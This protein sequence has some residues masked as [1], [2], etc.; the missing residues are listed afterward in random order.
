MF[1]QR[2]AFIVLSI[3]LLAIA[4]IVIAVTAQASQRPTISGSTVVPTSLPLTS[5]LAPEEQATNEAML[6]HARDLM[7]RCLDPSPTPSG[8][9]EKVREDVAKQEKTGLDNVE[10]I[11]EYTYANPVQNGLR[12]LPKFSD[13]VSIV[14]VQRTNRPNDYQGRGYYIFVVD[15]STGMKEDLNVPGGLGA[16]F[17]RDR[18]AGSVRCTPEPTVYLEPTIITTVELTRMAQTVL[19]Q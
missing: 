7:K 6:A 18:P 13:T 16:R 14:I 15:P 5:V 9:A 4:V 3:G 11:N 1:R 17:D 12:E 8:L 2:R 19:P 10:V